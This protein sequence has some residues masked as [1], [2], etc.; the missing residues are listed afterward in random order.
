MQSGAGQIPVPQC[1]AGAPQGQLVTFVADLQRPLDGDLRRHILE[2]QHRPVDQPI[3]APL[4][5][6]LQPIGLAG[7]SGK[8]FDP[9]RPARLERLAHQRQQPGHLHAPLHGKQGGLGQGRI[10][11][12]QPEAGRVGPGDLHL[13]VH[14]DHREG[15]ALLDV[16][17]VAGCL[18]QLRGFDLQ[19]LVDRQQ[20]LV[21]G[22]QLLIRGLQLLIGGLQLLVGGLQLLVERLQLLVGGFQLLD[23]QIQ[24][25]AGAGQL[26]LELSDDQVFPIAGR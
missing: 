10:H 19:L 11:L 21:G 1:I 13:L 2:H 25:A 15:Q 24:M 16:E 6:H 14:H 17:Q 18:L 4:G 23:D 26:L 12:H 20:F 8:T 22:L 9:A 7:G 3:A 5:H